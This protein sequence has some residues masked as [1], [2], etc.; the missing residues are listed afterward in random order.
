ME[1]SW[2][3]WGSEGG[4]LRRETDFTEIGSDRMPCSRTALF[5]IEPSFLF[6]SAC[7]SPSSL[8]LFSSEPPPSPPSPHSPPTPPSFTPPRFLGVWCTSPSRPLCFRRR[9]HVT[10]QDETFHFLLFIISG[11]IAR[12][13]R[14]ETPPSCVWDLDREQEQFVPCSGVLRGP[15]TNVLFLINPSV[16]VSI[17]PYLQ[18]NQQ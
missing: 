6:S 17:N 14:P 18:I 1:W 16:N 7:S 2:W 5:T 13:E 15:R 3:G 10:R 8:L 4:V 9:G 11:V 12:G